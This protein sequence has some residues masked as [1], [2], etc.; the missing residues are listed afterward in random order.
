M[1]ALAGALS[2]HPTLKVLDLRHCGI[3]SDVGDA[4]E[5]ALTTNQ[6]L[7]RLDLGQNALGDAAVL[8]IAQGLAQHPRLTVLNL[9]SNGIGPGTHR[10]T[11]ERAGTRPDM[12]SNPFVMFFTRVRIRT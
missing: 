8:G 4:F 3:T 9:R 6:S 12:D 7:V 5:V 1:A 10:N 11:Q 2:Q